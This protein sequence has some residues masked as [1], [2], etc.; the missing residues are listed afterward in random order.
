LSG[1][2]VVYERSNTPVD[3]GVLERVMERLNHRGPDGSDVYVN[4]H[5]AMGHWHFWTTPEEVGEKQPVALP[6]MPFLIVFDGRLDNRSELF[7]N[8]GIDPEQGSQISDAALVLYAYKRWREHCFEYFIGEFATVIFDEQKH[9]LVCA[10]DQL[11]GRTLFFSSRQTRLVIASEPWAVAGADGTHLEVNDQAVAHF[12][13]LQVPEDG[14]TMF[15]SVFELLPA[16]VMLVSESGIQ[17]WRYWQPDPTKKIRYK[18]DE[19]Y[20]EHFLSLLEES[21]RCRMRSTTPVGVLLSG[22]LDS[23]SVA[24]LAARILAPKQLTSVSYVFDKLIDC[25]ERQYINAVKKQWNIRSI[26]ILCDDAWPY[27]DWQDCYHDPN[28]P[29][30]V[31]YHLTKE[32]LY[33]RLQAEGFRVALTGGFGDHLYN[34]GENWLVDLI[35]DGRFR[36][37]LHGMHMQKVFNFNQFRRLIRRLV[38]AIP[39]GINFRGQRPLPAWLTT[40]SARQLQNTNSFIHDSVA[41]QYGSILSLMS[42][43]FSSWESFFT[44]HYNVEARFPYRDQRIIEFVGKVPSYQLY[45]GGISKYILRA[46][47]RDILPDS[48]L[49]RRDKTSLNSL[50]I[51]GI[52]NEKEFLKNIYNDQAAAWRQFVAAD[53]LLPRWDFASNS[54]KDGPEAVIPCLCIFYETWRKNLMKLY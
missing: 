10:R 3:L 28:Q 6:G 54:G 14:Q 47:L 48:V 51:Q 25:D 35:I 9:Q 8:L 22:G 23:A 18:T 11:G 43:H 36:D 32:R 20:A 17:K 27:K 37:A 45:F 13:A 34:G 30:G 5:I 7:G 41:Q 16:H 44:N 15:N 1:F 19:E 40:Y 52:E 50:F 21:I 29:D 2:A 46:S 4:D 24:C 33:G 38:E 12:F 39:G 31:L 42:A 53:W 49:A 26:Q